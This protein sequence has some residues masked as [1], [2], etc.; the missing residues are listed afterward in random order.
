MTG[1]ST[2]NQAI[3]P[4]ITKVDE[5]YDKMSKDG[6]FQDISDS[7]KKFQELSTSDLKD[8]EMKIGEAGISSFD[9]DYSSH[10]NIVNSFIQH[11]ESTALADLEF[12]P[13]SINPERK[14]HAGFSEI[15]DTIYDNC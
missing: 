9:G 2:T 1:S 4:V 3:V 8:A 14:E 5:L 7:I 6:V 13:V 10:K 11:R 15:L 12:Y